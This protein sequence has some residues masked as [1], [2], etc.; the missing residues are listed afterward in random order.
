MTSEAPEL[1]AVV[2]RLEKVERQNRRLKF[3][4]V[5]VLVL[6]AA[7]LLM[8][9][10][11]PGRVVQAEK[12]VLQEASRKVRAE[13]GTFPDGRV[14]LV[15]YDKDRMTRIELR[16]LRD[17]RAGLL[18]YDKDAKVRIAL[19]VLPDGRPILSLFDKDEKLHWQAP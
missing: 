1:A 9:Q 7:G 2:G 6:A 18:L 4:G 14:A 13:L 8:G 16:V 5:M 12:V 19:R 17:D 11:T 3:A 15:L 10:A